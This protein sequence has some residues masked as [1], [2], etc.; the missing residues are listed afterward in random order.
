MINRLLYK[1]IDFDETIASTVF[2]YRYTTLYEFV[3]LLQYC[4]DT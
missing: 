2:Y 3:F 1:N 4:V